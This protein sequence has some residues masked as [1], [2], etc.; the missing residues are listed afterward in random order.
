MHR[1][2]LHLPL[3]AALLTGSAIAEAAE[4]EPADEARPLLEITVTASPLGRTADDLVQ[5][6]IVLAGEELANKRR[7]TIGQTLEH[8]AGI[9]ST[10]F[11][12]G[13]G[14]PVIRGQAGPRVE[15][16]ENGISAMDISNLSPDH[17]VAISPLQASQIEVIKGPAT[18][19]YG[20]NAIGGVVNVGNN[21]LVTEITPGRSGAAETW[22]GSVAGETGA[23]G[24]F[25]Y[26]SGNQ[27]WHADFASSHAGDYRIPGAA[28]SDG[29]GPHGRLPNSASAQ[30]NGALAWNHVNAAGDA[31]G[32]SVSS[33][34]SIYGLPVE[35][36][37]FIDMQQQRVDTQAL[38]RN[39]VSGIE[40]LRIRASQAHYRHTEFEDAATPGTRFRNDEFQSR[41]EAVH[42]AVAG[43]RGVIGLQAGL[44][45]FAATGNEAYVQ[46][47]KTA[48]TALF[49]VE[50]RPTSFGKLEA[51]A[52]IDQVSHDPDAGSGNPAR[53]FAPLSAS[54]G[55]I[56]N[57]DDNSHL[58]LTASHAERAPAIEELYAHGPHGATGTYEIGLQNAGKERTQE[59]EVS[60]DHHR[61]RL[62]LETSVFSRQ[63]RDYLYA[64]F[65]G[66]LVDAFGNAPGNLKLVN[67]RQTRAQFQG[68]EVAATWDWLNTGPLRL[69]TRV[70]A[71][72]V[73][74]TLDAAGPVP[75]LT[76]SRQ[77]LDIHG[78]YGRLTLNIQYTHA[79]S[80][81]RIASTETPTAGY[82]LLNADLSWRLPSPLRGPG[83]AELFLRAN[84]LLDDDI[85]RSTSFIK[86]SVPAPG[87]A[88]TAGVRLNF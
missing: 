50:E 65:T 14:R 63:T 6:V 85:R 54:A 69:S 75:R 25:N 71:D 13:A 46:P 28:N 72:Q 32:I 21:R 35:P 9:S 64:D 3:A 51:G 24:D 53:R 82:H 76:P 4:A 44:R 43:F 41:I 20:G 84:N 16:L 15:V 67:Y 26:G 11:G 45:D 78:H 52:R 81:Q 42:A 60:L 88:I 55:V 66:T 38:L 40:S 59:F 56:V 83:N 8:E 23:S 68:Y 49:M 5:P 37:A 74:G 57:V 17:A 33:Y 10:D 62:Q 31:Y 87:R 34:N 22:A 73:R 30:N 48:S 70:F 7:G 47:V 79:D 80:Q 12:A 58:K 36:A 39:P 61:G 27:Q 1:H 19:L 18:L 77:G 29:N 2:P 86:D